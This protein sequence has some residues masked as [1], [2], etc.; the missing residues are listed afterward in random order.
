[1]TTAIAHA[2]AVS[3]A[4]DRPEHCLIVACLVEEFGPYLTRRTI[5]VVVSR[6]LGDPTVERALE[7]SRRELS[8][9]VAEA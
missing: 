4:P 2:A 9:I 1:M 5:E 8:D 6:Q 3:T 7:C